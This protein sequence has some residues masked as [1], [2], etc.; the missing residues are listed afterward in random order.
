M[1]ALCGRQS[2]L[3]TSVGPL[4]AAKP[5]G[6]SLANSLAEEEEEEEKEQEVPKGRGDAPAELFLRLA[7][8]LALYEA[9]YTRSR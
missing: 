3:G 6:G 4:D 9:D 8:L 7:E 1:N 5:A 2:I